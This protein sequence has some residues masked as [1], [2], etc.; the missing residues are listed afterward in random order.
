M[1]LL[2]EAGFSEFFG[3]ERAGDLVLMKPSAGQFH[4][5]LVSLDH[6]LIHAHAGLRRVVK[7]PQVPAQRE[8]GRWR[9]A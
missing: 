4:L 5:A 2:P 8:L 3:E 9:F 7:T 1:P 6:Q